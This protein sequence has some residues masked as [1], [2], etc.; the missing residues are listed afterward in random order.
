MVLHHRLF[1]KSGKSR[2]PPFGGATGTR[3]LDLLRATQTLF[4]LSYNPTRN[5]CAEGI[6]PAYLVGGGIFR[7]SPGLTPARAQGFMV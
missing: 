1:R 6:A 5:I 2:K 4:Q 7:G 3:T